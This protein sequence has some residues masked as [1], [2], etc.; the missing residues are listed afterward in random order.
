MAFCVFF[1]GF[2]LMEKLAGASFKNDSSMS[3][4]K[5]LSVTVVFL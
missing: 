2:S 5:L 4:L 1:E 3:L